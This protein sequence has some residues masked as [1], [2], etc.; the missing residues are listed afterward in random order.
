MKIKRFIVVVPGWLWLLLLTARPLS[1]QLPDL[2]PPVEEK[3]FCESLKAANFLKSTKTFRL[4]GNVRSVLETISSDS[5]FEKK[6]FLPT[7]KRYE[8]LSNGKMT[9]FAE[10]TVPPLA[11]WSPVVEEYYYDATGDTLLRTKFHDCTPGHSSVSERWFDKNGYIT[12]LEYACYDCDQPDHRPKEFA[13]VF[14]YTLSYHWTENHEAVARRYQYKTRDLYYERYKNDSVPCRK[15]PAKMEGDTGSVHEFP[16]SGFFN[17]L[18]GTSF[19]YDSAGRVVKKLMI[20]R[21]IKNS[22]NID[23]M[24]EIAY[25]AEGNVAEI[26][27]SSALV[28]I[29]PYAFSLNSIIR[30]EYLSFDEQGNWTKCKVH[31]EPASEVVTFHSSYSAFTYERTIRYY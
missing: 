11:I 4:K 29:Q 13:A 6:H 30:I 3:S 14:D 20:D 25:T 26:K 18:G 23:H 9:L 19:T 27:Y 2:E 24:T 1:A 17:Q 5:I 22:M 12:H 21:V 31:V 10:D 16:Y 15:K 7:Q 28:H 8:F